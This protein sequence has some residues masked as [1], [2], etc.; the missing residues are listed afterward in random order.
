MEYQ[1]VLDL[2]TELKLSN[3]AA[4]LFEFLKNQIL[5]YLTLD[6]LEFWKI[7]QTWLLRAGSLDFWKITYYDTLLLVWFC[8]KTLNIITLYYSF[9]YVLKYQNLWDTAA[10]SYNFWNINYIEHGCWFV[11]VLKQHIFL[12]FLL[13]H[14]SFKAT[15]IIIRLGWCLLIHLIFEK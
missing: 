11:Y 12:D 7:Y 10:G 13:V 8:L 3:F 1:I 5:S 15:H 9:V 2:A 6:S 14:L 4:G